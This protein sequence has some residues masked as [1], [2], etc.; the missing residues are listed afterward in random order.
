LTKEL[1]SEEIKIASK[2]AKRFGYQWRT[3][4]SEDLNSELI[5]WILEHYETVNSWRFSSGGEGQLVVS[6]KR[7]AARYCARETAANI[8]RPLDTNFHYTIEQIERGLPYVWQ[9]R[10]QTIAIRHERASGESSTNS[11][12][13]IADLSFA[14]NSLT[15]DAQNILKWRFQL[16]MG[17]KDIGLL[18]GISDRA[19]SARIDR[20]IEKLQLELGGPPPKI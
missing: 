1:T 5:L 14:F 13:V 4:D 8:H 7:V 15:L 6:L 17:L 2:I 12:A 9:E 19:A 10:P 3:I 11:L 16:N 20:A 18:L